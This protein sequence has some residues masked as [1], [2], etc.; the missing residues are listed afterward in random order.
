MFGHLTIEP[1]VQ[2]DFNPNL[3]TAVAALLQIT[4]QA[5][6]VRWIEFPAALLL[7]LLAPGDPESGAIYL[8]DRAKG[9]W[10]AIDFADEQYGGYSAS[11]F[12]TLLSECQFLGLVECP[13]LLRT[14]L[15]WVVSPGKTPETRV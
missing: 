3:H 15:P 4:E 5:D 7:L 11:Q 1:I 2:T 6:I 9:T 13:G 10:Y 8:L 12:D 14:Q